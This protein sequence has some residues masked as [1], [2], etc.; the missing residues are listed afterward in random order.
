MKK[1][2]LAVTAVLAITG[3][4]Q[5]EDEVIINNDNP[6]E[7]NLNGGVEATAVS[8]AAVNPGQALSDIQFVRVDGDGIGTLSDFNTVKVTGTMAAG[9]TITFS[10]VQYY[11]SDGSTKANI[12]GFYP[13]ATSI[14]AGLAT[15]TITGD[16]DVLYASV[17]SGSK[18]NPIT[19]SLSFQHK[20]TQFKFVV[21]RDDNS[22]DADI[23]DV[24]VAIKNV[25]TVF[26]MNLADDGKLSDWDT[27][28]S[29]ITP[30]TGATATVAGTTETAG[31]MLEPNLTSLVLTVSA[32][33]YDQSDV[34]ITG[35]DG[36]KFEMGKAYTITL[37]F[38]G[39]SITPSG[40]IADWTA[41]TSGGADIE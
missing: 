14:A 3:C 27:P 37:T 28:K 13:K 10:P 25:N 26:K 8:R 18:K 4:S 39:K 1:I 23:A 38:K 20:L 5:N 30:I 16:E 32:T 6:V 2:L 22:T 17:V 41:G 36:G 34:T 11:P 9:G 29:T 19:T 24:N 40:A 15:M 33:G 12:L 7:I 35:T 21:K 31:F